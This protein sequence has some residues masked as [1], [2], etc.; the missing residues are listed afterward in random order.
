[1]LLANSASWAD[2]RNLPAR[3]RNERGLVESTQ[4]ALLI[5]VLLGVL[6]TL[7]QASVWLSGRSTAQQAAMAGAEQ[8]A[9]VSGSPASAEQIASR[10]AADGGLEA[11]N[12]L[13]EVNGQM[14]AVT[15]TGQVPTVMPGELSTV[16]ATAH[17][18]KEA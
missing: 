4:W 12:V 15:V 8:A 5:P 17:R 11:V 16:T 13:V 6:F 2:T 14:I 3:P 9:F 1:M 10:I 18:V 7:I